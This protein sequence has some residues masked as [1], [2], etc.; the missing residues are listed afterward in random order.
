MRRP[1]CTF[2][3]FVSKFWYFFILFLHKRPVCRLMNSKPLG[4]VQAALEDMKQSCGWKLAP[5]SLDL[6]KLPERRN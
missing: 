1:K 2:L 4:H 6:R 3:I 5:S